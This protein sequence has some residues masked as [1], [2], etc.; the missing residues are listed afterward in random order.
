MIKNAAVAD[1]IIPLKKRTRKINNEAV[2]QFHFLKSETWK[3]VY[4][5]SETKNKFNVYSYTF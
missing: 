2:V 3:S 4:K 5:D 1:N